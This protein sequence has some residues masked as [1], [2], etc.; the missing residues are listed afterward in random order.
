M[1]SKHT[2]LQNSINS[3]QAATFRGVIFLCL[4]SLN[5][6]PFLSYQNNDFLRPDRLSPSW[7]TYSVLIDFLRPDRLPPSWS[8]LKIS[9]LHELNLKQFIPS[10]LTNFQIF[11]RPNQAYGYFSVLIRFTDKSPPCSFFNNFSVLNNFKV[12]YFSV[13]INFINISPFN[14]SVKTLIRRFSFKKRIYFYMF[15]YS[16]KPL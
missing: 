4:F 13:L 3:I 2:G 16:F 5:L 7:S 11:L 8:T 14:G 10:S 15:L 6:Q 12:I 9:L 1:F